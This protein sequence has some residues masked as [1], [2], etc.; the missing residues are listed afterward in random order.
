M[1]I[2]DAV[3]AVI[4]SIFEHQQGMINSASAVICF[5]FNCSLH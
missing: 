5:G 2:F 4:P 1:H 3:H